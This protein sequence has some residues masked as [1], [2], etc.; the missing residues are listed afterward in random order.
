MRVVEIARPDS[1]LSDQLAVMDPARHH[2]RQQAGY[3]ADRDR[4]ART[5]L[6]GGD[7]GHCATLRR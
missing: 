5:L 4:S 6:T 3:E 1:R 2:A 7:R